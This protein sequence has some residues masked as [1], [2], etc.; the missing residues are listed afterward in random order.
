MVV[1]APLRRA[2]AGFAL[3]VIHAGATPKRMPVSSETPKAKAST[4]PEGLASI[5]TFCA[6][7][8]GHCDKHASTC[9]GDDKSSRTAD[10]RED[11]AFREQLADDSYTHRP[12][13]GSDGHLYVAV[14]SAN[15]QKI[16]DVGAGDE[17]YEAGDPHQQLKLGGVVVLHALDTG[18]AGGQNYPGF[19]Q[20][21]LAFC[22]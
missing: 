4:T 6:S 21:T 9:V 17:E 10:D 5:G 22:I 16:G 19:S 12:Q 3:D 7:G 18:A 1:R 15:K 14:H 2:S 11:E 20:S 8:K 13:R